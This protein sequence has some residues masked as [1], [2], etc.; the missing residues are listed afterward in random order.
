MTHLGRV[1]TGTRERGLS[2]EIT[3]REGKAPYRK[4][5]GMPEYNWNTLFIGD[6][7]PAGTEADLYALFGE[8]GQ[9]LEVKIKRKSNGS[10]VLVYAFVTFLGEEEAHA[11]MRA[12][13]DRNFQ[14]SKLR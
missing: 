5:H 13:E 14:G 11:A 3:Q 4:D 6:F 9:I 12:M 10:K 2:T 8:F 7:S 1:G